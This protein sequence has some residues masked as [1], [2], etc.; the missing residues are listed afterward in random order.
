MM[1]LVVVALGAA[2]GA[3]LRFLIERRFTTPRFPS[4][5]LVVNVVGSLIAGIVM[6]GSTGLL[7]SF[8]MIGFCGALTTYSGFAWQSA[9][10][11]RQQRG[12]MWLSVS[13]MTIGCALAFWLG[14][15]ATAAITA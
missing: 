5:L 8:L 3:P 1:T 9:Q 14:Y 10:L 15:A 13:A 4:G 11:W 6:A 7:R 12:T 2:L